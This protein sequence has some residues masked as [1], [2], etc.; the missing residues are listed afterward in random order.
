MHCY[1]GLEVGAK[2][3]LMRWLGGA[4]WRGPFLPPLL[5]P[6]LLPLRLAPAVAR[7]V[8]QDATCELRLVCCSALSHNRCRCCCC[9]CGSSKVVCVKP[10]RP[11]PIPPLAGLAV[12]PLVLQ[13]PCEPAAFI[14]A[15]DSCCCCCCC[16]WCACLAGPLVSI[17]AV[18]DACVSAASS[19]LPCGSSTPA[20]AG[21]AWGS[22]DKNPAPAL[23]APASA[24]SCRRAKG[25][26]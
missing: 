3:L 12:A 20:A 26:R 17:A 19:P 2:N 5:L 9:R 22:E 7:G 16:C 13:V 1:C 24:P 15:R 25:F 8:P 10:S 6:S 21:T 11:P 23:S 14:S 18:A 4:S